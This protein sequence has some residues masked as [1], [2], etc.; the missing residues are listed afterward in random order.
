MA[1]HARGADF[2]PTLP[3]AADLLERPRTRLA[4]ENFAEWKT[5]HGCTQPP[6]APAIQSLHVVRKKKPAPG[7]RG[8]KSH[9]VKKKRC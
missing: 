9:A 6:A 1:P 5:E 2:T 7:P 8:N 4:K 3:W